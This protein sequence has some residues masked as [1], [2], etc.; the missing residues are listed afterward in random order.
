MNMR[1]FTLLFVAV[2]LILVFIVFQFDYYLK[3]EEMRLI[4][5]NIKYDSI[6]LQEQSELKKKDSIIIKDEQLIKGKL[7]NHEKRIKRI[8]DSF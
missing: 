5:Q 6:I 1:D 2:L 4:Q 7:N 8:E 3:S